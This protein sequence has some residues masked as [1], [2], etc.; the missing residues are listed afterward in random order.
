MKI[1]RILLNP[2][3]FVYE[4]LDSVD[5]LHE[6]IRAFFGG[7]A[8]L[9]KI[10]FYIIY[11][12]VILAIFLYHYFEAKTGFS[13]WLRRIF[14]IKKIG[15]KQVNYRKDY[16][17]VPKDILNSINENLELNENYRPCNYGIKLSTVALNNF[18]KFLETLD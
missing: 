6:F 13:W 15:L 18:I 3:S 8:T 7:V 5:E 17:V 16:K 4:F 11:S 9:L 2:N 10:I 1:K 14:G 12:P